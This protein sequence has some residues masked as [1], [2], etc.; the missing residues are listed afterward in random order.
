MVG[1]DAVHVVNGQVV[2]VVQDAVDGDGR[3]LT[4][5][6]IQLQSEAA[7]CFYR[8]VRLTPLSVFPPRFDGLIRD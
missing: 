7:E 2:M 3:P 6:Q 1:N 4:A 8:G 5:G